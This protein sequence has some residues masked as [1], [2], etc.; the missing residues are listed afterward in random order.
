MLGFGLLMVVCGWVLMMCVGLCDGLFV[1]IEN[2]LV[3]VVI[4]C[5]CEF[6]LWVMCWEN[7]L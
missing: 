7:G 4:W 1:V 2:F 6:V 5:V 3:V